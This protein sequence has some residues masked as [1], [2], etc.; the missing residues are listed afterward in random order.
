MLTYDH[1]FYARHYTAILG[2]KNED[3]GKNRKDMNEN[4]LH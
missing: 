4:N 1:W 3:F 2:K